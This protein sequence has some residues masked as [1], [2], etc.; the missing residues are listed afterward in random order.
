MRL[1]DM[2]GV[3]ILIELGAGQ[4]AQPRFDIEGEEL[5]AYK[6]QLPMLNIWPTA[7]SLPPD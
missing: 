2:I 4:M 7:I 1:I 6:T 3:D 5:M